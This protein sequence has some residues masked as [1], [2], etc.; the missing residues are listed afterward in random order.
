MIEMSV[1]L[2]KSSKLIK[3]EHSID[4]INDDF[5]VANADTC[6]VHIEDQEGVQSAFKTN[7]KFFRE[8]LFI[9]KD[10]KAITD[11]RFWE[12]NLIRELA[13]LTRDYMESSSTTELVT[14]HHSVQIRL[15]KMPQYHLCLSVKK[16]N[17]SIVQA[18]FP[19]NEFISVLLD[20]TKKYFMKLI[21]YGISEEIHNKDLAQIT[22]YQKLFQDKY[23]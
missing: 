10:G 19:E 21:S 8:H 2:L 20:V 1:F 15:E 14:Y 7:K 17:D 9:T 12:T 3:Q 13:G 4:E 23:Q 18:E 11:F 22:K 16:N 6:F 5:L